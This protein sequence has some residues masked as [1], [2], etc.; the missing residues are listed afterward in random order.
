MKSE[1]P[2]SRYSRHLL[3]DEIG[4]DG[5]EK[6]RA[7]KVLVVGAGGL[8]SPALYYLAAAGVGKIGIIDGDKV[9]I[10]NL[11]RQVVH[12]TDD[13]GREK[14]FSAAEKIGRLNPE[15]EVERYPFYL[16]AENGEAILTPYDY[17]L[18]CTD[19]YRAK[20]LV[21]DLCVACGKPF[22]HG[23]VYRFYGQCFTYIPGAA[24]YRCLYP[25][26]P[27]DESAVPDAARLGVL[28][29]VAGT[30]GTIQA[31]EAIK[32]I[33]ASGELCTNR[34]LMYDALKMTFRTVRFDK[35]PDCPLAHG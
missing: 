22:T 33:T 17:V 28:G 12:F 19:N 8:G 24:C 2:R 26:L 25:L 5:H 31:T 16:T 6:L 7:A 13:I 20:F 14:S 10:T 18:E 34:I 9:D 23:S 32:Y 21:N 11:Q 30:I 29:A 15:V 3:L 4:V 35:N 27:Q 1:A